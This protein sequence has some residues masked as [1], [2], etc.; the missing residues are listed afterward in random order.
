MGEQWYLE[1]FV[2]FD[3]ETRLGRCPNAFKLAVRFEISTKT[4]QRSIDYFRDRLQAPLEY[5]LT[6]KGYVYTDSSYQMPVARITE[7]EL[8]ALLIS[9]KL[10]TE[11]AGS[12]ADDLEHISRRLGSLLA[13][14]L[15]G[16]TKPEDAFSFR[17]KGISPTDPLVFK[18]VTSSLLQGK[19]LTFCYY[20]PIADDFTMRTVEPHH[21]VNYMGNWHLIAYC[22]LRGAWRDFMLGR[23]SLTQ[24]DGAAF[25]SRPGDEWRPYWEN[26]FGIFQNR[27]SCGTAL[28]PRTFALG[29]RGALA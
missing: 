15:P 1:R 23:M 7:A 18:V 17:W 26:T 13:A 24:V 22:H 2:W 5:L 9:R 11:A 4:A 8:L 19:L 20:S 3:N 14:N 27:E 12:L 10:I 16:R 29:Q 6:R 25:Q 21:M 28:H